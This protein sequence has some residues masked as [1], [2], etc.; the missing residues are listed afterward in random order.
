MKFRNFLPLVFTDFSGEVARSGWRLVFAL[1][2]LNLSAFVLSKI[3]RLGP[4]SYCQF[5]SDFFWF[6]VRLLLILHLF[7]HLIHSG[8]LNLFS[9]IYASVIDFS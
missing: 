7:G 6:K 5:D 4:I 3:V 1:L 9:S 8:N 2:G